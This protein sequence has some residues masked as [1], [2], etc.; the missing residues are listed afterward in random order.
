MEFNSS[1]FLD[2]IGLHIAQQ[3]HA[4]GA[5]I[6]YHSV[7]VA[8]IGFLV[9]SEKAA[10]HLLTYILAAVVFA[11]TCGV[12][13]PSIKHHQDRLNVLTDVIRDISPGVKEQLRPLS[14]SYSAFETWNIIVEHFFVAVVV[15]VVIGVLWYLRLGKKE[16]PPSKNAGKG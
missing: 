3:D 2:L 4:L 5:W 6:F 9:A 13:Y 14:T 8:I 16:K 15:F 11:G 10:K 1:L 12:L 7:A